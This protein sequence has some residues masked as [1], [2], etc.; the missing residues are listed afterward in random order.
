MKL[1]GK[2]IK[3][4]KSYFPPDYFILKFVIVNSFCSLYTDTCILAINF[5]LS[6]PYYYFVKNEGFDITMIEDRVFF[7]QAGEYKPLTK[8][9]F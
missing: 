5:I 6:Y 7:F 3:T 2:I 8:V 4:A 9:P 1:G